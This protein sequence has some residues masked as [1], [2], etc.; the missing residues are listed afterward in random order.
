[1]LAYYPRPTGEVY[2]DEL[3]L[4][5]CTVDSRCGKYLSLFDT[6]YIGSPLA[7]PRGAGNPNPV[8]LLT[9]HGVIERY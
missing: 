5:I 8:E 4:G 7:E 6:S 9:R 1:M 2:R 3:I